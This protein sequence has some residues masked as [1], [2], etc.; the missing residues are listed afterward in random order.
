[1]IPINASLQ[2]HEDEVEERFV[3][4]SGPGGQNVNKVSTAVELRFDVAASSLP[5]QVKARLRTLARG[6]MTA[7]DI[8][9]MEKTGNTALKS[10]TARR[11]EPGWQPWLGTPP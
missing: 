7:D 3:R 10:G 9:V 5:D 2:L 8:L 11:P 4:A 6:R 1:M